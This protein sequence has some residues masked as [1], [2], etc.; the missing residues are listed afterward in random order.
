L[1]GLVTVEI[2]YCRFVDLSFS[3]RDLMVVGFITTSTYAMR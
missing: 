2:D 3:G 1:R